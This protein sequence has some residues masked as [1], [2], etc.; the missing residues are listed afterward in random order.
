MLFNLNPSKV[1]YA[2]QVIADLTVCRFAYPRLLA[3]CCLT[4]RDILAVL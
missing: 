2:H 3:L 4:H 1:L